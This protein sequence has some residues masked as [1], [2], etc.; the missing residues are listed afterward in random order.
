[1]TLP[2]LFSMHARNRRSSG[3][4]ETPGDGAGGISAHDTEPRRNTYAKVLNIILLPY[5]IDTSWQ[6]LRTDA[7]K[8]LHKQEGNLAS[9]WSVCYEWNALCF[10][11]PSCFWQPCC[12]FPAYRT[13]LSRTA[14]LRPLTR[15]TRWTAP[16]WP[17]RGAPERN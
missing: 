5:Q 3:G 11:P 13:G 4:A 10:V 2:P 14:V 12:A 17:W 7:A 16:P 9:L 1:M 8:K 6:V 15:P